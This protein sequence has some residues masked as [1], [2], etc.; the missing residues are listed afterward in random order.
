[1]I[2]PFDRG[3]SFV[4][5]LAVRC[6]ELMCA[7]LSK[8][9]VKRENSVTHEIIMYAPSRASQHS[10]LGRKVSKYTIEVW[11]IAANASPVKLAR[12]L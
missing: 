8:Y 12:L 11:T 4:V 3:G 9:S 2:R 1:M 7:F 6:G 5:T 10:R